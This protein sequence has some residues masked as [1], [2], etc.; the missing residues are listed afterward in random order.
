MSG[1]H[2]AFGLVLAMGLIGA[3]AAPAAQ[4]EGEFLSENYPTTTTST[5][6]EKWVFKG[7]TF[8]C[9]QAHKEHELAKASSSAKLTATFAGC[10]AGEFKPTIAMNTCSLVLHVENKFLVDFFKGS[11]DV[12]CPVGK[13]ITFV[14]GTC[15]IQV[16]TQAFRQ[17]VQYLNTTETKPKSI[18]VELAVQKLRYKVTKDGFGCPLLGVEEREDGQ[19]TSIV[20]ATGEDEE[21][22]PVG[23]WVE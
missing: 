10:T 11:L 14:A 23:I 1:K 20:T 13:T 19:I 7:L 5:G 22:K 12:S 17:E 3:V 9:T 4:A 2:R 18:R 6:E 8:I 16:G 15:E 21:G